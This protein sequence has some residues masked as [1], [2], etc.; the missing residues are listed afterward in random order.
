MKTAISGT[1]DQVAAGEITAELNRREATVREAVDHSYIDSTRSGEPDWFD[2][3][4][5]FNNTPAAGFFEGKLIIKLSGDWKA[6]GESQ[7]KKTE[8]Y[9]K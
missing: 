7:A 6:L 5:W 4:E 1:D 2:F 3:S 8:W 9:K